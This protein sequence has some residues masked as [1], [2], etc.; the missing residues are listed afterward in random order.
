MNVQSKPNVGGAQRLLPFER[1]AL[2]LQGG[3]A[4]G[5]YQAGVYEALAESRIHPDWIA[6]ISIGGI[7]AAIIAG[8]PPNLRVD[9]LR[10]FWTQ[11]TSDAPWNWFGWGEPRGDGPRKL[12]NHFSANLALTEGA[13]GFFTARPLLPWLQPPGTLEATSFYDTGELKRTLERL[14]DFDRLNAGLLRFSV[15]AVNVRTGN[16]V[17]FD[18]TTHTIQPEHV[19]ASGASS[20][21]RRRPQAGPACP[22]SSHTPSSSTHRRARRPSPWSSQRYRDRG[23]DH[24]PQRESPRA[25]RGHEA[26]RGPD[27]CVR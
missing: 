9:R 14:V 5:A 23:K 27:V 6:G 25:W 4:L 16:F 3:G 11:V 1:I 15:G 10:E 13:K 20:C 19:M 8:N 26:G 22:G 12:L 18:T 21:G 7:N 2:V 24:A 17:Y